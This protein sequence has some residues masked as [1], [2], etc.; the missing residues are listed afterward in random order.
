M[1]FLSFFI[2]YIHANNIC[3]MFF[4]ILKFIVRFFNILS[5]LWNN[6]TYKLVILMKNNLNINYLRISYKIAYQSELNISYNFERKAHLFTINKRNNL[7]STKIYTA[8]VYFLGLWLFII[9]YNIM[10]KLKPSV[11]TL[12]CVSERNINNMKIPMRM[13]SN[14]IQTR[15]LWIFP[16]YTMF[17]VLSGFKLKSR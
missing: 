14:N 8:F 2:F 4:T 15:F 1:Y 7:Y 17:T 12:R 5:G 13:I 11:F 6:N 3:T 16:L 10:H 9:K